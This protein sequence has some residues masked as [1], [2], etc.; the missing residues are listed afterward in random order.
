MGR[1][2]RPINGTYIDGDCIMN[3]SVVQSDFLNLISGFT[4]DHYMIHRTGKHYYGTIVVHSSNVIPNANTAPFSLKN[5]PDKS[6]YAGCFLG[7]ADWNVRG[8]GYC[9]CGGNGEV[10]IVDQ[11]NTGLYKYAIIQI[12]YVSQ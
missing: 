6:F 10:I 4:I 1:T 7:T 12:D 8:V 11:N 9:Y 3:K 2:V 5:K